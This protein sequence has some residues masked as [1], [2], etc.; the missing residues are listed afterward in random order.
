MIG[1]RTSC[2]APVLLSVL[3]PVLAL[4]LGPAAAQAQS[5]QPLRIA[6]ITEP[7][8][9]APVAPATPAPAAGSA[10]APVEA[11]V[12]TA[13]VATA[14]GPIVV[15]QPPGG[16]LVVTQPGTQPQLQVAPAPPATGPLPG[17][18]TVAPLAPVSADAIGLAATPGEPLG[19]HQWAGTPRGLVVALLQRLPAGLASP[20]VRALAVRLLSVAADPPEGPAD[21][22]QPLIALRVDRLAALGDRATLGALLAQLP[23]RNDAESIAR[24][25]VEQLLLAGRTADGCAAVKQRIQQFTGP[26]WQAAQIACQVVAGDL[27]QAALGVQLL[28]ERG[29]DDPFL[30]ALVD[31]ANGDS[32]ATLKPPATLTVPHYVLMRATKRDLPLALIPALPPAIARAVAGDTGLPLLVRAAAAERAAQTGALGG[33]ELGEAYGALTFP[34]A[35]LQPAAAGPV[36]VD[37][38]ARA[39][40]LAFQQASRQTD[41]DQRGVLAAAALAASRSARLYLPTALAYRPLLRDLP[42]SPALQDA[43]AQIGRALLA[44]GEGD[45]AL[46]WLEAGRAGPLWPLYRLAAGRRA[47]PMNP[48]ELGA[49]LEADRR[50]SPDGAAARAILAFSL[51]DALGD[52]PPAEAWALLGDASASA[53]GPEPTAL[54]AELNAAADGG[55]TGEAVAVIALLFGDR[56]PGLVSATTAAQAVRALIRLKLGDAARRLAFETA[57]TGGL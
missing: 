39:R 25:R 55:R 22:A 20:T 44:A 6:P 15:S 36:R 51:F 53:S 7:L 40:A 11:P 14:P 1:S 30:A 19:Q 49:W 12:A 8:G 3:V 56:Q 16:G 37:D 48:A 24:V 31:A 45:L 57:V 29:A 5:R 13:P 4:T 23:D 21:P 18:V 52:P 46:R 28:S 9:P 42:P 27:R 32:S 10:P 33:P 35:D 17:A 2:A 50:R 54:L 34:A 41:F 26:W 38:T 47:G 43:G